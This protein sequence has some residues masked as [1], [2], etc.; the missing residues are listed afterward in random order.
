[1]KVRAGVAAAT[2][3]VL[4][5]GTT[6][7]ARV[8]DPPP[9][10]RVVTAGALCAQDEA[11]D[12]GRTAAG[13]AMV[14]VKAPGDSRLRWR[15]LDSSSH[16]LVGS[17]DRLYSAYFLREADGAGFAYW[18]GL[19]IDGVP[20]GAISENFAVSEEFLARYGRLTHEG[21]VHLVY[22]NVLER[23]PDPGGLSYWIDLLDR[24]VI[25]RG[26]LMVG[27]SES[28]EY[29]ARTGTAAPAHETLQM[30][31]YRLT[32]PEGWRVAMDGDPPDEDGAGFRGDGEMPVHGSIY[33]YPIGPASPPSAQA[34]IQN[35]V[36]GHRNLENLIAISD[37]E[38][39]GFDVDGE[40]A[41]RAE[42]RYRGLLP[43]EPGSWR[44]S[45]VGFQHDGQDYVVTLEGPEPMTDRDLDGF[46]ELLRSWQFSASG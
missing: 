46:E 17:V 16:R 38:P 27:F 7:E 23:A 8:I 18:I 39:L 15:A 6:A 24:S 21:F 26:Q 11:G 42:M 31:T 13:L 28:P 45:W 19:R 33:R 32:L 35:L 25:G 22:E 3:L 29:R 2:V 12:V 44:F 34:R 1:M 40:E 14:C 43:D 5:V 9:G 10:A 4:L 37:A 41:W 20:L 30:P 36:E